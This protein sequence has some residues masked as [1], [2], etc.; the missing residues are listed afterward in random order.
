MKVRRSLRRQ[1][2]TLIELLVVI[3]IIGILVGLL[4]PAV[5]AAR[6]AGRRVQCQNNI[7]NIA[8]ALSQFSTA[9]NYFPNSGI[10]DE[11][12]PVVAGTP[13]ASTIVQNPAGVFA[14]IATNP[15][16]RYSWVV[17]ALPYLD[18]QDLYNSWDKGQVYYST[19]A[20]TGSTLS[21]N[22]VANTSIA[23][24][25]C[26]D[27]NS[28]QAGTG[29]LSYVVNSGFSLFLGDGSS[30][31]VVNAKVPT[32]GPAKL[33]WIGGGTFVGAKGVTSKLGVMFTGSVQGNLPY[34]YK[35]T[36]SSIYDGAS[37]TLLLSENVMGGQSNGTAATG[38]IA[39]NWACPLPQTCTFIGSHHICD[40]GTGDCSKS[41]LFITTVSGLQQD[42]V[43]WRLANDSTGLG[44]G[45]NIN[46]GTTLNDKGSSPF[47]NSGHPSGINTA[48]CD[49]SVKFISATIDG[50]VY[51]KILTPAGGKL[52]QAYKQLPVNQDF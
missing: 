12:T 10:V 34:D 1:G 49:G 17:E 39:T 31:S 28:F 3:S 35:T 11:A 18:Q 43:D 50:S 22:T 25:R 51:A 40:T 52:S 7:K 47:A 46:F 37:T 41:N 27:D 13:N 24:L 19:T 23:I 44:A 5:N 14:V 38:M 8:L 21:N 6:E 26:P 48:M 20:S 32:Y 4:L 36:L 9:K 2:F 42:G 16:L 30:W 29:N 15:V 33:D 45:E